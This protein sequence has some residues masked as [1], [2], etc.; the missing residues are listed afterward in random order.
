[1]AG[2]AARTAMGLVRWH[3][4]ANRV[5]HEDGLPW[6]LAE[7]GWVLYRLFIRPARV[8]QM[9]SYLASTHFQR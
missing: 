1:M 7:D 9:A 2:I 4:D 3:F 5:R 8:A 6:M